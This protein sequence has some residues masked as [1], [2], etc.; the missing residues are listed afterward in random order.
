MP[1]KIIVCILTNLIILSLLS[2]YSVSAGNQFQLHLNNLTDP[3]KQWLESQKVIHFSLVSNQK[4]IAFKNDKGEIKGIIADYI[5]IIEKAIDKKIHLS[6]IS[7]NSTEVFQSTQE[8]TFHGT[9]AIFKDFYTQANFIFTEEYMSTPIYVFVKKRN[10]YSIK[11]L[12]DLRL[13]TVAIIKGHNLMKNFLK[14]FQDINIIETENVK[15]Q[16]AL[17][18]Y[19]NVDAIIGYMNYH[20]LIYEYMFSNIVPAFSS[21]ESYGLHMGVLPEYPLLRSILNKA[22]TRIPKSVMIELIQYWL[23]K[24][25]D[26]NQQNKLTQKERK[27]I[28]EHHIVRARVD[29][30]PP[31][32]FTK[33]E[34]SGISVDYL[35]RIANRFGINVK[36][37]PAN[38]NWTDSMEDLKTNRHFYDLILTMNATDTRKNDF[39][40]SDNYLKIPWVIITNEASH[41]DSIKDLNHKTVSVERNFVIHEKLT[42][43]YP[44]ISLFVVKLSL[45]ALEAV[46]TG[47]A[48]AYIGNLGN[49]SF[50]IRKHNLNNLKIASSTPFEEH[51]QAMAVRKD[52]PELASIITKGLRMMHQNEHDEIINKWISIRYEHGIIYWDVIFWISL[53]IF[54]SGAIILTIVKVNRRLNYEINMRKEAMEKARIANQAKSNFL[55]NMSHEIRTPMNAII[56]LTS[57]ALK[58]KLDP[59]QHDYLTK[60][61]SAAQMLLRIIN[62]VL[63]FSKI[64]AGKLAIEKIPFRLEKVLEEL[65]NVISIK[66]YEK[67]LEIIFNVENN[68]PDNLLGDPLRLGQILMNLCDNAIKFT[69]HGEIIVHVRHHHNEDNIICLEFSVTDTGIG[70]T[71]DHI[72]S[73]FQSF[74]QG[75]STFS[76]RYGGTG[77]GLAISK[78]LV[79]LKGGNIDVESVPG[80]GSRFTFT[81]CFESFDRYDNENKLPDNDQFKSKRVLVVDDNRTTRKIL[82]KMLGN[83]FD[84]VSTAPSGK[85]AIEIIKLLDQDKAF[86]LILID[87]IMPEM[88]GIET[89]LYIKKRLDLKHVPTVLMVSA[90]N[91]NEIKEK[92]YEAGVDCLL[93]KPVNQSV[94]LDTIVEHLGNVT[95][96][97]SDKDNPMDLTLSD[98]VDIDLSDIAGANVLLVED[99]DMNQLIAQQLLEDK[100]MNTSIANNG[101]QAIEMLENSDFDLVLMDIQ[102][103]VMDGYEAT[104]MIRQNERLKHLPVIAM[105]AHVFAGEKE[106]CLNTGMDDH[107][108]KPIHPEILYKTIKKYIKPGHRSTTK[109]L[110]KTVAYIDN[111]SDSQYNGLDIKTGLMYVSGNKKL[112]KDLLNR[113]LDQYADVPKQIN[114]FLADNDLNQA[115]KHI[116]TFK[117]VSGSIGALKI[118]DLA[119]NI[120][121]L[122]KNNV[123]DDKILHVINTLEKELYA[124]LN[125]IKTW[126]VQFNDSHNN[127]IIST[128]FQDI[129][130][131]T[132]MQLTTDLSVCLEKND[133]QAIDIIAQI[134][135]FL[136][137]DNTGLFSEIEELVDNLSFNEAIKVFE[138]WKR[139]AQILTK[140]DI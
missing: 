134:K 55:A 73:L 44:E 32:M 19:E 90:Y 40:F 15:N 63:D 104:R 33:P 61:L 79:E 127:D 75:D 12:N 88:D 111:E 26:K 137:N 25:S 5:E 3:E 24:N 43:N 128:P 60:S 110:P 22:I 38:L 78:R 71:Q 27:W 102:M 107:I 97:N 59:Q 117:G 135:T 62:D 121:K 57:L 74:S 1:R 34:F 13:K 9:V 114:Q 95:T 35:N 116:H 108:G 136:P 92:A 8:S 109:P 42:T 93:Q 138:Q 20:Y 98:Q 14:G 18:E 86:D 115:L 91:Y 123:Q 51:T 87:W 50:L 118:Y 122:L 85:E 65:S 68:I 131:N 140:G 69:D 46:S 103:P 45:D 2:V 11:N 56:G 58:T 10:R 4:P 54:A 94:L 132:L 133:L 36:F 77:L 80:K 89:T 6:M 99:N 105:T 30:W 120:E 64:E 101:K 84:H 83:L 106:K 125:S 113:Y 29:Y 53:V 21:D 41:I 66:A 16:M 23:K 112:Y 76:R 82:T 129:D 49:A 39:A 37:V 124:C 130:E 47:K 96:K 126:I 31:Y 81:A 17:L 100:Q 52:W 70:M 139:K 28:Q 67:G 48:F 72:N 7:D 119:A